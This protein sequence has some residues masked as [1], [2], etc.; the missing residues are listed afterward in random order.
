MK[1]LLAVPRWLARQVRRF[2]DLVSGE[3]MRE[4]YGEHPNGEKDGTHVPPP[5]FGAT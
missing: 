1:T 4:V 5:T 3:D 2:K